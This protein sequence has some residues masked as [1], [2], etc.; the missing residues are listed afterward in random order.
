MAVIEDFRF[1]EVQTN[2]L[3][4]FVIGYAHEDS[5]SNPYIPPWGYWVSAKGYYPRGSHGTPTDHGYCVLILCEVRE[6]TCSPLATRCEGTTFQMCN[7]SGTQWVNVG[8]C[9][10]SKINHILLSTVAGLVLIDGEIPSLTD[11]QVNTMLR[12]LG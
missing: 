12:I 2:N 6:A 1:T 9:Q 10:T 7:E 8:T 3:P 5:P 4:A 11:K